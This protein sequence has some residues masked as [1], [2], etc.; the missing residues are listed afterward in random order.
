MDSSEADAVV[1]TMPPDQQGM[2]GPA[3]TKQRD[4][5]AE[6]WRLDPAEQATAIHG[7][8]LAGPFGDETGRAAFL[9]RLPCSDQ[10]D[11]LGALTSP[12]D[13]TALLDALGK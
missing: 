10:A 3:L 4:V 7:Q 6:M 8:R 11:L 2:V 12:K 1:E 13:R 9:A 5:L